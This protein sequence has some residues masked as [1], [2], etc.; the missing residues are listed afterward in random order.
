MK[1][2]PV[3]QVVNIWAMKQIMRAAQNHVQQVLKAAPSSPEPHKGTRIDV[4]V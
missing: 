2:A 1:V 4:R 3:H